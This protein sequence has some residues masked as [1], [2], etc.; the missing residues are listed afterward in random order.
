MKHSTFMNI[1]NLIAQ[2]SKCVSWQVGAIIVKDDRIIS[3]GYNGTRSGAKNCCDHAKEQGWLET[4]YNP[5]PPHENLIS[6][7]QDFREQHSLWSKKH[8]I[9]AELNSILYAARNGFSIDGAT[10]YVTL[11]PC[12]DCAKA[13]CQSGLKRIFYSK[14]YDKNDPDWDVELIKAGIEL[15][16]LPIGN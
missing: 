5:I 4:R 6:L 3:T 12:S 11:S 1:A 7:N 10:M 14:I 2:E 16:H 13:I 15:I 8:E 9:H